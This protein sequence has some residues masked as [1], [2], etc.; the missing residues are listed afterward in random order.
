VNVAEYFYILRKSVF[1][2]HQQAGPKSSWLLLITPNLHGKLHVFSLVAKKL[3]GI[4]SP[5]HAY[6]HG[7]DVPLLVQPTHP[8]QYWP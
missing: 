4:Q 3:M 6:I 8:V 1:H 2:P 5:A 7:K